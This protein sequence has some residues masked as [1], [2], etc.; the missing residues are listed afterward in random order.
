M[1]LDQVVVMCSFFMLSLK[2]STVAGHT[3]VGI[4]KVPITA[5]FFTFSNDNCI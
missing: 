2:S 3:T 5:Y 4:R 1:V